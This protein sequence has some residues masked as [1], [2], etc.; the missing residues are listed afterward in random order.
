MHVNLTPSLF[1]AQR[2][3]RDLI[4]AGREREVDE[5]REFI[6]TIMRDVGNEPGCDPHE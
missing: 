6:S 5:I 2:I 3:A 1:A 4:A